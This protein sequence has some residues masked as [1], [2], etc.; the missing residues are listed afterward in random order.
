MCGHGIIAMT[1]LLVE[2]GFPADIDQVNK[3]AELRIDTPAGLVTAHAHFAQVGVHGGHFTESG[4]FDRRASW[5]WVRKDGNTV[6]RVSFANVPSFA[7]KLDVTLKSPSFSPLLGR[8]LGF[9][10]TS[11]PHC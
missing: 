9:S 4:L 2:A 10:D 11:V 6:E 1:K 7:Y 8:W 3:L 5:M